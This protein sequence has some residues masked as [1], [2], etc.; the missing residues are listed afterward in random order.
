MEKFKMNQALESIVNHFAGNSQTIDEAS[1]REDPKQPYTASVYSEREAV[2]VTGN[3]ERVT[4]HALAHMSQFK[5]FFEE[6]GLGKEQWKGFLETYYE[7]LETPYKDEAIKGSFKFLTKEEKELLLKSPYYKILIAME[8]LAKLIN[9]E[10][11]NDKDIG[12]KV[13]RHFVEIVKDKKGNPQGKLNPYAA[14]ALQDYK[15]NREGVRSL[16]EMRFRVYNLEKNKT[17]RDSLDKVMEYNEKDAQEN[18]SIGNYAKVA[19][20]YI[21]SKSQREAEQAK[22]AKKKAS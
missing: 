6:H 12:E 22:E 5:P 1:K 21:M 9:K 10:N 2:D 14:A 19:N 11:L 8:D 17:P 3:S 18:Y 7:P 4:Q 13:Q 16:M 15:N 20:S